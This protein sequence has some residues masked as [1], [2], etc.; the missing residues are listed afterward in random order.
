MGPDSL[1]EV[2]VYSDNHLRGVGEV[3]ANFAQLELITASWIDKLLN[4]EYGQIVAGELS[5]RRMRALLASLIGERVGNPTRVAEFSQLLSKLA[6][7]E[8]LRNRIVHA[9]WTSGEAA[10]GLLTR[11]TTTANGLAR[12]GRPMEQIS[13]ADV[14]KIADYIA[15]VAWEL[16][17]FRVPEEDLQSAEPS[18]VAS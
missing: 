14:K 9:V 18:Q 8:T 3:T 5:F 7:A 10:A 4:S 1:S 6:K 12:C 2:V 13:L 11:V 16:S 15:T 17:N